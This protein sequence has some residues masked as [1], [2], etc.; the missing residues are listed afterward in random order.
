M[1]S[2]SPFGQVLRLCIPQILENKVLYAGYNAPQA[3]HSGIINTNRKIAAKYYF[4]SLM[5]K[6]T[7]W[8]N[9]CVDCMQK[10][11]TQD[12]KKHLQYRREICRYV[13]H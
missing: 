1:T 10:S 7:Y 12:V 3:G 4:P 9:N 8:I 6:V 13:V 11:K 2:I 5:K